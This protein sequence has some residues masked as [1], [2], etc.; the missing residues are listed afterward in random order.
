[1]IQYTYQHFEEDMV[2][3]LG[4]SNN[5]KAQMVFAPSR[6]GLIPAVRLSHLKNIPLGLIESSRMDFVKASKI[7]STI[8]DE[9]TKIVIVDEILDSGATIIDILKAFDGL[10]RNLKVLVLPL[11]SLTTDLKIEDLKNITY[12]I[13]HI[14]NKHLKNIEKGTWVNFWWESP[15]N[16]GDCVNSEECNKNVLYAHCNIKDKSFPLNYDCPLFKQE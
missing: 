11:V 4:L 9:V 8:P 2:D 12:E 3:I 15:N 1:M 6:G 10:N 13:I 5:F 16:C 7:L 14:K